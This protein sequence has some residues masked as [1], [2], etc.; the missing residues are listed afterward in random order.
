MIKTEIVNDMRGRFF[1]RAAVLLAFWAIIA[2]AGTAG[3]VVAEPGGTF[4]LYLVS[5]I[6]NN[7]VFQVWGSRYYPNDVLSE[8]MSDYLLRRFREIPRLNASPITGS[9]PRY[10]S[11]AGLDPNDIVV[12][13]NLEEFYPR[14]KDLVGSRV[15]WDVALHMYVHEGASGSVIF[16]SVIEERDDRFYVL[17]NDVLE[18]RP[19]YWDDFKNTPYWRAIRSAL[20]DAFSEVVEGYNGY[21]LVG[22]IVAK[23]ERVDGSLSVPA[24]KGDKL[25]HINIGREDSVK[26][27]DVFAVTRSSSVRTIAPETPEMHFPQIVGRVRVV[28]VKGQDAIVQVVKESSRAPIQLGDSVSAPLYGGRDG[29]PAYRGRDGGF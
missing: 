21:R 19:V 12:R 15:R 11:A 14:K 22:Q 23:A 10:W 8:R 25:Y 2:G 28:F 9:D 3:A 20:D 27:G 17:Y 4:N 1:R 13:I 18:S 16:D 29:V 24:K 26:V 7:S 6:Q 5:P